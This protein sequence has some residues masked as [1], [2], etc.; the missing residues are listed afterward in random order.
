SL[1]MASPQTVKQ[2]DIAVPYALVEVEVNDGLGAPADQA[3]VATKMK[4]LDGTKE[5]PLQLADVLADLRKR[6]PD[7]VKARQKAIDEALAEEQK[8]ALKDRKPTGP[9]ETTE[10]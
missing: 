9:R 8:V 4:R 7:D 1:S 3:F 2:W 6:Y 10:L 5:F